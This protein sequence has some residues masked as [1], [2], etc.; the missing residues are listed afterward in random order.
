VYNSYGYGYAI[1][2]NYKNKKGRR[3][4]LWPEDLDEIVEMGRTKN[5]FGL[6]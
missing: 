2:M 4:M 3:E 6:G 5:G 1:G